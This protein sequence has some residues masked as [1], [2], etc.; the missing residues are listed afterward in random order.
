MT[1]QEV[2]TYARQQNNDVVFDFGPGD[3]KFIIENSTVLDA[4]DAVAIA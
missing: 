1:A 2:G 3:D 4:I